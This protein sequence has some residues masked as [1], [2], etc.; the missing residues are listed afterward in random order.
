MFIF[1]VILLAFALD[2]NQVFRQLSRPGSGVPQL[3]TLHDGVIADGIAF[4]SA[5][6]NHVYIDFERLKYAPHTTWN[7]IRHELGH[8][9]GQQHGDPTAEMRYAVTL[10]HRGMVVDDGW[11]I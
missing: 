7:V 4:T 10:D 9:K 8:T 5:D 2:P 11:F 1:L 6:L 3:A